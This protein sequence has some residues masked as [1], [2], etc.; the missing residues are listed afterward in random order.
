MGGA[1]TIDLF[2]VRG[3]TKDVVEVRVLG[4]LGWGLLKKKTRTTEAGGG[5]GGGCVWG[6]RGGRFGV[7]LNRIEDDIKIEQWT[8]K[9]CFG[10]NGIKHELKSSR[11]GP[12]TTLVDSGIKV[13][14][15]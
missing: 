3:N 2:I 8:V 9:I 6:R 13:D 14:V 4:V 11:R 7:T 5:G 12:P 15:S 1:R 10:E